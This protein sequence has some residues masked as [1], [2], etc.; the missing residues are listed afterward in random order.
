MARTTKKQLAAEAS[1][2]TKVP[3]V[4]D[5]AVIDV[6]GVAV[7]VQAAVAPTQVRHPWRSMI[8][9]I[10]QFAIGVATLVPLVATGVYH[11][12]DQIPAVLGQLL[13]VIALVTRIMAVPG[14]EDFLRSWK[15]LQWLAT[16]PSPD[17]HVI[18][19]PPANLAIRRPIRDTPQA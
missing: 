1:P 7:E 15:I 18:D 16:A 6:A 10:V 12:G 4:V 5:R 9:T 14:V 19:P 17:G 8:R 2:P 11:G 13:A 3:E